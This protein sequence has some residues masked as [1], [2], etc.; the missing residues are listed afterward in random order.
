[1]S[2]S[3]I[4]RL[5]WENAVLREKTW[6][7]GKQGKLKR[8]EWFFLVNTRH[9][10]N[11][12]NPDLERSK[13]YG[14]YIMEEFARAVKNGDIITLNKKRHF[15]DPEFIESVKIRYVTEIGKGKLKKNGQPGKVGGTVHF[16][17]LLTVHHRSNISLEWEKLYEFF[18]PFISEYFFQD[19]PFIGRPRLVPQNRIQEYM[20][21]GF[22]TAEWQTV[23]F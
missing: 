2:L 6:A 8:S 22:E 14:D 16:H 19:K 18:Q 10:P 11:N 5:R 4:E 21:K 20:E 7:S 17:V 15:W 9:N 12:G 3:E 13:E 23:D 1:M